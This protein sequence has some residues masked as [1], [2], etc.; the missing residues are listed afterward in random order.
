[1]LHPQRV[2][3]KIHFEDFGGSEFERLVFAY[4]VRA[5]WQDVIWYG[6]T[7]KDKGQDIVGLEPTRDL[8]MRKTIVQCANRSELTLAKA[9]ADMKAA[10]GASPEVSAFKFVV[11]GD[12]P[13]SKREA[14]QK[15]AKSAGYKH[16]TIWSG[17]DFEEHLRLVGADLLRRFIAGEVFPDDEKKLRHFAEDFS[18]FSDDDMLAMFAAVLE[19][20]AFNTP[21]QLESSLP[22]F[23]RAIEDTIA[24]FNT[25][26][27]RTREGEEIRLIP[28]IHHL[29]SQNIK[30]KVAMVVSQIDHLR[31]T[32]VEGLRDGSIRRCEC[33]DP[34]CPVFMLDHR[35]TSELDR[36]RTDILDAF[37]AVC[38]DFHMRLY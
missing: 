17:V 12:V 10:R 15:T 8:E 31:R 25:G 34:N 6:Q 9:K 24:A 2:V 30:A 37:R 19:R 5:G 16:L 36:I 32:F 13:A 26:I 22:N 11:R 23:Q 18:G 35:A 38:P 14:I 7:G 20:P 3:Q 33:N 1:M 29:H 4:H 28:S 21:F 27:W